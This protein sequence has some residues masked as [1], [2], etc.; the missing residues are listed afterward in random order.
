MPKAPWEKTNALTGDSHHLA[1]HCADV[2]ACFECII[3][4][5]TFRVRIERVTG[6]VLTPTVMERLAVLAFLHDVGKLHPG[7][8]ARGWPDGSWRGARNGHVPQGAAIFSEDELEPLA[9]H[10]GLKELERWGGG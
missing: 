8:Q 1:H 7:F 10:L 3:S 9:N 4:L 5:P 6:G 2:A